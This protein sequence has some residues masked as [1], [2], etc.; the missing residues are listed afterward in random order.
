M[1]TKN[2]NEKKKKKKERKRE[3]DRKKEVCF[4]QFSEDFKDFSNFSEYCPKDIRTFPIISRK[5]SKITEDVRRFPLRFRC[6]P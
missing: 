3:R 6:V 5:F 4:K 1:H 2:L